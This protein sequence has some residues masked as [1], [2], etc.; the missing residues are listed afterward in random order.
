MSGESEKDLN[1]DE[2]NILTEFEK[3][4]KELEEIAA[5]ICGVLD[6]LKGTAENIETLV[7]T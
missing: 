7:G 1:A 4:D 3:N 6:N 5:Q 2:E